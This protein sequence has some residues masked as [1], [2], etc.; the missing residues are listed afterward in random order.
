MATVQLRDPERLGHELP[1]LCMKCGAPAMVYKPRTF[2]WHPGWVYVLLFFGVLPFIIVAL[3]LTKR[4]TVCV[5]LCHAHRN[6]WLLRSLILIGS[7]FGLFAAGFVLFLLSLQP[8]LPGRSHDLVG[9]AC[10]GSVIGL[11]VWLILAAVF[12]ATSIRAT[13]ITDQSITL[14]GVA[15]DFVEAYAEDRREI[16]REVERTVRQRWQ[17]GRVQPWHS[18]SRNREDNWVQRRQERFGK[19]KE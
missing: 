10:L 9:L 12:S 17:Q 7:F 6:H 14:A 2:S 1:D 15:N 13:Q 11:I 8:G 4:M 16:P 19:E 3:V 18:D 5:P